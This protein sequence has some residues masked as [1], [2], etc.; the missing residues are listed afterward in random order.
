MLRTQP[1]RLWT[2]LTAVCLGLLL[3]GASCKKLSFLNHAGGP[4]PTA[5]G[6]TPVALTPSI[7]TQPADQSVTAGQPAT[8]SVV[9]AGAGPLQYQ[10]YR[11][12]APVSGAT[13][14]SYTTPATVTAD[15]GTQYTVKV[16]NQHGFLFSQVATLSVIG[17]VGGPVITT[18]PSDTRVLNGS[19]ATFV[20]IVSG[21]GPFAYRWQKNNVDIPGAI[22]ASYTTPPTQL[23]DAGQQFRVWISNAGGTALSRSAVL[24]V[25]LAVQAPGIN[26]D[27]Q[28]QT[29]SVGDTATF[30]VIATATA[31]VTYQWQKNS[32]NIAGANGI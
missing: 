14:A 9:A 18:Q 20:V 7:V 13:G 11:F 5:G 22:S 3:S 2:A 21:T 4:G 23:S 27:P 32:V 16:S 24:G 8:F 10:W 29:V 25:D 12:G 19:T 6:T 26:T 1:V 28:S 15:N 17:A 31:P 30:S